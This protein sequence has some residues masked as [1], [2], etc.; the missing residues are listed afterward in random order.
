[1]NIE[2]L[3]ILGIFETLS[4]RPVTIEPI[5]KLMSKVFYFLPKW[6]YFRVDKP[7][8]DGLW[9]SNLNIITTY[10]HKR[11]DTNTK[12]KYDGDALK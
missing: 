4:K 1:M 6:D 3:F 12:Y 11:V 8:I 10:V 5:C 7:Y 9:A 2:L